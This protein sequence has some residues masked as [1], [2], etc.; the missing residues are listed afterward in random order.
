MKHTIVA[1]LLVLGVSPAVAQGTAVPDSAAVARYQALLVGLRDTVDIAAG[2]ANEFRRDLQ[3]VGETTVLARASR[4]EAACRETRGALTAA[5]PQLAA[6][7][8]ASSQ[9]GARDSLVTA[10][11]ALTS[12]LLRD[13]EQG[14]GP[15][16]PGSRADT[17]RAW[18]PN[19]TAA[20]IQAVSGY[21]SAAARL[22][23]R[24]G[25]DLSRR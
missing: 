9:A 22:A 14:L 3:T 5:R 15:S 13:C 24:L 25:T 10:I 6:A 7:R 18:G 8:L 17:L 2:R 19:R 20:L 16:G 4:L 12:S 11:G 1:G 23:R 21:H